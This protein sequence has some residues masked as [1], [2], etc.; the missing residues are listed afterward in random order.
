MEFLEVVIRLEEIK[1]E[2]K[3]VKGMLDWL[4]PQGVKNIQKFLRLANY[5]QQFI[6][7]F[8]FIARLLYDSVRKD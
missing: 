1:I 8:A 2:K 3:K 5:Y 7:N 6:K 4:T